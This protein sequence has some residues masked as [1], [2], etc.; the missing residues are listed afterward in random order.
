MFKGFK[1]ILNHEYCSRCR[2]C[3][4]FHDPDGIWTPRVT[5]EESAALARVSGCGNEMLSAPDRLRILSEQEGHRCLFLDRP[6]YRCTVYSDRPFE[7]RL[8]PFLLS[9]ESDG[10]KLYVHLAC[11]FVQEKRETRS[12]Q[13]HLA[14]LRGFFSRQE[15]RRFLA[16][17]RA[18]FP[19]YSGFADQLQPL[20]EVRTSFAADLLRE[21][22]RFE[23]AAGRRS[24]H[25][26]AGAFPNLFVWQDAF[27]FD[28]QELDGRLCVYARQ[29]VG[30]FLYLP[31][32]GGVLSP[33]IIRRVFA[34]LRARNH[35]GGLSRIENVGREEL[36]A[37][38]PALYEFAERGKEYIYFR[39]D[40]AALDG[41]ALKSKRHDV[42]LVERKHSPSYR[43]YAPGDREAC[44]ELFE[45]WLDRKLGALDDDLDALPRHML[46]DSRGVHACL[47]ELAGP[48]GLTGRVAEVNGQVAAYTFGCR[49]DPDTFCVLAEV[50]DPDVA[51]LAS[52]IF[53]ALADDE[54]VRP[55]R[56]LNAMDDYGLPAMAR[57]KLSWRPKFL[58]PVY[59]VSEKG[60]WA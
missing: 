53:R 56:Y 39:R 25:L 6:G 10:V 9:S 17:N 5:P 19:D 2:E 16:E 11:P 26:S 44:R 52:F 43:A 14:T 8:Y 23:A 58:E 60:D 29:P 54:T 7:C 3:C 20:L 41:Q 51:G 40:I 42:N 38:D 48:L 37:F 24:G 50:A 31:P 18:V 28:F 30:S 1:Q 55:F 15:V 13:D 34:S 57:T 47:L 46:E 12:W 33:D 4:V 27:D 49:L 22:S 32:V 45:R 35:G 59:S 36:S 21:R